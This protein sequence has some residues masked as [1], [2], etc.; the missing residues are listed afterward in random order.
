[1]CVDLPGNHN[2]YTTDL[3]YSDICAQLKTWCPY[4]HIDS[5]LQASYHNKGKKGLMPW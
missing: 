3:V 1:M 4:K 5:A 2:G